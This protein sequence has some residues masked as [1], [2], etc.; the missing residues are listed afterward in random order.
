[1]QYSCSN[2]DINIEEK[3]QNYLYETKQ[4]RL[5]NDPYAKKKQSS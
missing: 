2:K 4:K 3:Y 1:M 5:Q